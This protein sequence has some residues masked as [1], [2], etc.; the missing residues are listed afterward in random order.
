[1]SINDSAPVGPDEPDRDVDNEKAINPA[2][3]PAILASLADDRPALRAAVAANP[4]A[5]VHTLLW[6]RDL[7]EPTID[8]ALANNPTAVAANVVR[9]VV[10][11]P[12][13]VG[14]PATPSTIHAGPA[15]SI[16]RDPTPP[17]GIS[18]EPGS[19]VPSVV[20]LKENEA[21]DAI[22]NAQRERDQAQR[23]LEE[24]RA[25]LTLAR[26]ELAS[27]SA[28]EER[29]HHRQRARAHREALRRSAG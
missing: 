11:L 25:M 13:P 18:R 20:G 1:M 23:L 7:G 26:K 10:P 14:A 19:S 22:Q 16:D 12:P 4:S 24:H 6:L 3:S 2:T 15:G 27:R 9:R 29:P 8:R 28:V 17:Q 5:P 21:R